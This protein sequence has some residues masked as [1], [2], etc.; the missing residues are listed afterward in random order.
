MQAKSFPVQVVRIE[1]DA[2]RDVYTK[3]KVGQSQIDVRLQR[4]VKQGDPLS[5]VLFNAV[6]ERQLLTLKET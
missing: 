1:E 2:Y 4:G 3:I 5:P 6:M